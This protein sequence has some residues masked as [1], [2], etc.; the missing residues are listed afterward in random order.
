MFNTNDK[1]NK[2][3]EFFCDLTSK[4]DENKTALI[5]K[6]LSH[7]MRIRMLNQ[8]LKSP[9]SIIE[10]KKL[11]GLT[12]SSV[13]FHLNILEEASLVVS[14][15]KP[16]KK[17][18]TLVFY[19]NF[20][21]IYFSLQSNSDRSTSDTIEQS[22]GVGNFISVEPIEYIR[23]ATE[24]EFIVLDK[25]DA[26]NPLRFGAKL[27]C[28]DNGSITYAFSNAFAKRYSVKRLDFSLEIC[29]ESPY[30][31]NDWKSEIIFSVCG[32]DVARYVSPA[33][34]GGVRGKLNPAWWDDKYS[35]YG[36]LITVSI[37]GEC[38]YL[39]GKKT[40]GEINLKKLALTDSDK[41]TFSVRTELNSKY[42]GGF[43]IYGANFGNEPQDIVMRA[44]IDENKR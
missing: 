38:V 39:N 8:I 31:C 20:S 34:F 17:G 27:I 1:I 7:P 44:L 43:N 3:G 10:L 4:N 22:V 12:N 6:A 15:V 14:R 11:N 36:E 28:M 26:Y 29:S 41:I 25:D 30:Y 18:K 24:N 32:T 9:S 37:D 35:Q 42:A 5:A 13:I 21:D 16:N 40:G 19:V 2:Y 23:L 33:D